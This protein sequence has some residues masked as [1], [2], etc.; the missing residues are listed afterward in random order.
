MTARAGLS[1]VDGQKADPVLPRRTKMSTV[2][3]PELDKKVEAQV[4]KKID[5]IISET[6]KLL[7]FASQL[8]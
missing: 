1:Y 7:E 5:G 3:I 8:T 2:C 6:G 4:A